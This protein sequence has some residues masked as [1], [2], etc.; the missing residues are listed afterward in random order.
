MYR[1]HLISAVLGRE[2]RSCSDFL[3]P[4]TVLAA[5]SSPRESTQIPPRPRRI[6][7]APPTSS[8]DAA[9]G[10]AR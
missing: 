1:S 9:S 2:L 4:A 8:T 5:I 6:E 7:H 3:V 10:N